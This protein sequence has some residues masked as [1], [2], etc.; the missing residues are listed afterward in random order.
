M[1]ELRQRRTGMADSVKAFVVPS[2]GGTVVRGPAGGPTRIMAHTLNTAGTF[3]F[4]ENV[5]APGE[6][7]PRHVH[8]REDEMWFV[9][10]GHFRCIADDNLFDAPQGS[11]VFVPRRTA[12]CLQNIGDEPGR[13]LVMFTPAGMERFFEAHAELPEGP[14]DPHV[15]GKLAHASFMDVV[16][17]PLAVSHPR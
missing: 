8:A 11:F 7:P 14:I 16:G 5:I 17:P 9:L 15:Y 2:D 6:G 1:H 13:V 12:H 4:L 3:T 10:E